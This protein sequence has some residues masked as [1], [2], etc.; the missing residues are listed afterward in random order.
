MKRKKKRNYLI[1]FENTGRG[2][3]PS[4]SLLANAHNTVYFVKMLENSPYF[5]WGLAFW[6]DL[7]S[8]KRILGET[9]L[10]AWQWSGEL[11]PLPSC[12]IRYQW[13]VYRRYLSY[14]SSPV[15][16]AK[17]REELEYF[18]REY[19]HKKKTTYKF[20]SNSLA[21]SYFRHFHKFVSK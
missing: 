14:L 4:L 21:C 7:C 12:G 17:R 6:G 8:K 20:Q 16:F 10:E 19:Q 3:C 9:F 18:K 15:S 1:K 5:S 2:N 13:A 11:R